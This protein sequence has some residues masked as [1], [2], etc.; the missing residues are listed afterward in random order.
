MAFLGAQAFVLALRIH[1]VT[2]TPAYLTGGLE[3]RSVLL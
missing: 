1:P 3:I 2:H